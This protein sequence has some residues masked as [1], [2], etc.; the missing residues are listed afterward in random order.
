MTNDAKLVLGV[1]GAFMGIAPAFWTV[2]YFERTATPPLMRL[3]LN[4]PGC[5]YVAQF[6]VSA[7]VNNGI[8]V[9]TVRYRERI[10]GDAGLIELPN[11][12]PLEIGGGQVVGKVELDDGSSQPWSGERKKALGYIVLV[13]LW[14]GACLMLVRQGAT[15]GGRHGN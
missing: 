12:P 1:F 15:R 2:G 9:V 6:G 10:F 5:A 7:T 11:S 3:T 8:C 13:W 4:Q 14:M